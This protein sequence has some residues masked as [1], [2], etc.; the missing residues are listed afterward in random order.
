MPSRF[1]KANKAPIVDSVDYKGLKNPVRYLRLRP[2]FQRLLVGRRALPW[3][4][5]EAGTIQ[6]QRLSNA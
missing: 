1:L 3:S 5:Q 2:S 4:L 6:R